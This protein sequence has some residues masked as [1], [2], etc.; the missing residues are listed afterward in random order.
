[1]LIGQ[2]RSGKTSLKKSLRGEPFNQNEE[3]T[4][5]IDVDPSFFQVSTEIWK[6]G[7]KD[8]ETSSRTSVSYEYHAARVTVDNMEQEK[9]VLEEEIRMA[10]SA[11]MSVSPASDVSST[12]SQDPE[13]QG[14][15]SRVSE[16]KNNVSHIPKDIENEMLKR[17][18]NDHETEDEEGIYSVL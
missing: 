2:D 10:I 14:T 8:P 9:R 1:M 12:S 15:S 5:G 16:Q 13:S 17:L 18:Q 3:S 6:A 7:E 11:F 4:V